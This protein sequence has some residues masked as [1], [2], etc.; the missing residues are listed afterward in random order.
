MANLDG[1]LEKNGHGHICDLT[2][3][4]KSMKVTNEE[5]CKIN[6]DLKTTTNELKTTMNV[7][8]K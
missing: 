7:L 2:V 3:C 4:L 5:L 6:K 1:K 8:V